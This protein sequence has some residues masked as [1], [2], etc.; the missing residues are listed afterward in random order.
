MFDIDR[1]ILRFDNYCDRFVNE[2][3]S[4]NTLENIHLKITHSKNVL[5]HCENIAKTENLN[6]EDF[7]IAQLCGLFHDIGR[8]EQFT[9]YNTFKDDESV[10]HGALGADVIEK[11]EFLNDLP[12]NI[13]SLVITAVLNHGLIRIPANTKGKALFFSGLIRD[14]DKADIFGIVAKYYR[15]KGPRNIALEY[16]LDD[17]PQISEKVLNCFLNSELISKDDLQTLN[18]FKTMQLAWIF[19]LN[20]NYTK[21]YILNC[22]FTDIVLETITDNKPK[23]Q[24]RKI[25]KKTLSKD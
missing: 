21:Q 13:K 16:G 4:G 25:I 23:D 15:S 18:D 7:F 24:I 20:F 8:F 1:Y 14:A 12:E 22:N 9:K 19:D 6:A 11:E 5:S 17:S 2:N 10:Y 3:I